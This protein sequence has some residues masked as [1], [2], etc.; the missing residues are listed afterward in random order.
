MNQK[1]RKTN[2]SLFSGKTGR[3]ILIQGIMQTALVMTSFCIGNYIFGNDHAIAM[4]MAFVTLCFIQ[5]FHAYNLKHEVKSTFTSNP[6]NNNMLNYSFIG[7]AVLVVLV[8][9]VP[10]LQTFFNTASLTLVEWLISL[11]LAV[12]IMPLVELQKLIERLV[13]RKR[14]NAEFKNRNQK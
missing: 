11:A 9:T 14:K 2:T 7:G 8:C 13:I 3:D 1:P 12:A 4:T 10:F 5:L 6:F